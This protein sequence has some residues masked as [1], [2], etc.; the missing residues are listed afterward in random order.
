MVPIID[1][2]G[3]YTGKV[4]SQKHQMLKC[5]VYILKTL[6]FGLVQLML[7]HQFGYF[8]LLNPVNFD[9]DSI[10]HQTRNIFDNG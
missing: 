6:L 2:F 5:F 3:S 7:S 8:S 9:V 10:V 1:M 4:T